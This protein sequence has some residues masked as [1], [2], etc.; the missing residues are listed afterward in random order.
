VYVDY[1]QN[2]RGKTVAGVYSARASKGA[3]VSTPLHWE[4]IDA[5][6]KP[7]DFTIDNVPARIAKLGDLWAKGM[8]KANDLQKLGRGK[9]KGSR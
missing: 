7:G 3:T 5:G 2:I 6:L 1:L 4:E 9:R 8:K